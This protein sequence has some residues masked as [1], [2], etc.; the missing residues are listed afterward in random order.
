MLLILGQGYSATRI[1]RLAEAR[2][3]AV[4]GVRRTATADT[5]AF[6]DPAV[7]EC[8]RASAIILSSV[9]PDRE[10]GADP[11]LARF[12]DVLASTDARLLYLSSTGVYGDTGGAVVDESAPVGGGRRSARTAADLAWQVLGATIL[13]L[14]GIYGPG[15]SAL[16]Q[17]RAGTARRIDRP[18]HRFNRIHVDD[19]AGATL[20][21]VESGARGIFN[22]VDALPAE[23][24][25][26]TE[27]ACRLLG[28]PLPPLEPFDPATLSPMARGFWSE[29]RIV[30][31]TRLLRTTGYR[32]SFPD[33]KAGLQA[34]AEEGS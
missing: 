2:G 10:T 16:D 17:V 9:P 15:R 22:I 20:A 7:R 8:L 29:G 13:R 11:V 25:E 31:G 30:A 27:A 32:L 12:G 19:I 3:L 33:Y 26:V 24:R 5:L 6:D 23:P 1:R 28:A 34:I 4:A 18:G 14:P 21:I